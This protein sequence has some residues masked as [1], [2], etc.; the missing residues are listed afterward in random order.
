MAYELKLGN[1]TNGLY[2]I[3]PRLMQSAYNAIQV[4]NL[5]DFASNCSDNSVCNTLLTTNVEVDSS[6]INEGYCTVPEGSSYS[7]CKE[8]WTKFVIEDNTI[9][10]V[11]YKTVGYHVHEAS[12][13]MVKSS[14]SSNWL[15]D[16]VS[17]DDFSL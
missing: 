9:K 15:I 7:E 5:S 14:D 16:Q 11:Y 17:V 12:I 1:Y 13:T 10:T 6:H 4:N 8:L 3:T 2:F